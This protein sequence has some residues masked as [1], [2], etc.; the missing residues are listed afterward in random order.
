VTTHELRTVVVPTDSLR[1]YH[2]NPRR[3]SIDVIVESLR[4]NGQYRP[5]VVNSR[6]SEVLAGNHT[7]Y[8]AQQLGWSEVAVTFIDVDP[9]QAARIVLVDNR[10]NDLAAYDDDLLAGLIE[11]LPDLAGTGY[12]DDD[13]ADLL[14]QLGRGE[15]PAFDEQAEQPSLDSTNPRV[16]PSCGFAW[17]VD[18]AG[19]V[20]PA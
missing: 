3:G 9:E 14:D 17:R 15:I 7:L 8:A 1:P 6:T 18:G 4:V 13:L 19:N 10:S 20:Q 11:S 16:C 12:S 2:A 5:L